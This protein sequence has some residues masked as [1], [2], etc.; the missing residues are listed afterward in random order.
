MSSQCVGNQEL[1]FAELEHESHDDEDRSHADLVLVP[2]IPPP[3]GMPALLRSP[4]VSRVDLAQ[5][6]WHCECFSGLFPW[7]YEKPLSDALRCPA[8]VGDAL[9]H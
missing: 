3:C 6:T 2:A 9:P 5:C 1:D 7:N 4:S 8:C